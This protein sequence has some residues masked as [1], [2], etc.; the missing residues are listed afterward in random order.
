[1]AVNTGTGKVPFSF[2]HAPSKSIPLA[3]LGFAS[4]CDWSTVPPRL[5]PIMYVLD[6]SKPADL[7][8]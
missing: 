2:S 7:K 6:V 5:C 3:K 4:R 8:R 1:M